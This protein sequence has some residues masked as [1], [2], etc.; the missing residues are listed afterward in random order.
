MYVKI[1]Q[2]NVTNLPD[3]AECHTNLGKGMDAKSG[4]F[5]APL[6]GA[7]MFTVHACAHDQ[8]KAL[9]TLRKNGIQVASFY[10]QVGSHNQAWYSGCHT[11]NGVNRE[12]MASLSSAWLMLSFFP[13]QHSELEP[14]TL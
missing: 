11:G 6:S 14:V 9:L 4:I 7:Y 8:H 12:M 13:A 3:F 5:S 1:F 2:P 10:D